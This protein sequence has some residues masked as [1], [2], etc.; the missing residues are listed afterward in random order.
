M[1]VSAPSSIPPVPIATRCDEIRFNSISRTLMTVARGGT[2]S[3]TSS[4]RS[5]ARQYTT[6][7]NTGIR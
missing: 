3:A 7:L 5:T 4:S 6:S 2:S 1:T